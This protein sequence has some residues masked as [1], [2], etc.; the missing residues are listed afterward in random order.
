M[1]IVA[2]RSGKVEGLERDGIHVFRGIPYATPP[3]GSRR[4]KAPQREETW[5]GVRE[6]T[7]F[8]PQSAQSEFAL[9]KMLGANRPPYSEDSLYL[10]V[11]TPACDDAARPVM[12]W[13][14]G[15]AFIW[16]AGDTPWYDG[17]RFATRGD[18]VLVTINYRLGPF[19]YLFLPELFGSEFAQSGNLGLL[20]QVAALEWVR[21][22]IS[23]FG[24]DANQ[25]TIFGESAGAASV[26][27]LLG[28]P[29]ARGLF[30]RAIAQSGA[31]SWVSTADEATATARGV[32]ERL[33][34]R[35]GDT[36]ALLAAPTDAVIEAL[37][38]WREGDGSGLPFQPVHDGAVVPHPPLDAVAAGNA[39]H[40]ALISGTNKDE[41][42][43]FQFADEELANLDDATLLERVRSWCGDAADALVADYRTRR[44]NAAPRDIWIDLATDAVFFYPSTR[45][46]DAQSAHAPTWSYFFTW[47]TP[48]LGGMLGSCH[49]LEIPFVF[50]NLDR[51]GADL[52]TGSGPERAGIATA[53]HGAW[54][55]FAR[56]GNP[57]HAGLPDWPQ[58]APPERPTM[59]FDTQ[60]EVLRNRA[61]ADRQ[62]VERAGQLTGP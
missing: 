15:G 16:G 25:V 10:N 1:A 8:S 37:P 43:L 35:A 4:W 55:A 39:E 49:A 42:K 27:T 48:L 28:T 46:L 38:G 20:D 41:I 57:N 58:Y 3:V 31:A 5:D 9:T 53:M 29:A 40:V 36:D 30:T 33:G 23:A 21:D 50:D 44:P 11:W 14:H 52:F 26:G 45:L 47:E 61:E 2:T 7:E 56:T 24:G 54:I 34:V 19:G 32:I 12:V 17:T 18:V 22:C 13:I 6:A 60:P 59:R 62:A 51:G